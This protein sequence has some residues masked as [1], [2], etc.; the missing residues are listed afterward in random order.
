MGYLTV[1]KY[2]TLVFPLIAFLFTIPF[3]LR[4]YHK[5]GSI[6]PLKSMITYLFIYYLLCAYFLVILPLPKVSEVA[7]M[8]SPRM[9]LVPFD[10]L[11]DFIKH[12]SLDITNANT[13]LKA[14]KESYFYV[15]IFNIFLT[16]PF[17]VFLRYYF[18][19]TKKQILISSFLLSLFF[20]LTQLSGLYFLYPR[21][22]RL[23]DVDDL[24]LNTAGGLLGYFLARPM[25]FFVP[26]IEQINEKAK[27]KGR[28]V[29]GLRR[30]VVLLLDLF[31]FSM[32]NLFTISLFRSNLYLQLLILFLYYILL[33]LFL[34]GSTLA[35][36]FLNIEVKDEN[37]EYNNYRLL[38]RKILALI[39]Y[40]LPCGICYII[41]HMPDTL[42]R[43]L[44]GIMTIGF[45]LVFYLLS[46]VKYLF[47][48]KKMVYEK[49]SKTKLVSTIK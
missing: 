39:I 31:I 25:T 6:S 38:L 5:Y 46:T 30:S 49:I 42:I 13:Y 48:N 32:I 1:I 20:E 12:S 14:M 44:L 19:C 47:T 24:I 16:L 33:P 21:G 11:L 45:I 23:F 35:Q 41:F 29:S 2:A 43:E 7:K 40:T 26:N 36:R 34:N 22:Y 8:T 18:K 37:N 17:G 15:P 4:E 10:F 3:I 9:Q 28:V 27:E